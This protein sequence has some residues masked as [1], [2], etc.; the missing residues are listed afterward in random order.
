[1]YQYS[2]SYFMDLYA[3]S[4]KNAEQSEIVEERINS[5]KNYFRISLYRNIGRSLFQK[6]RLIFSILISL[7]LSKHSSNLSN[8]FLPNIESTQLKSKLEKPKNAWITQLMWNSF[9]QLS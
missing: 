6:D 4:I 9:L 5:F 8:Y 3:S 2:L 1:M 7:K